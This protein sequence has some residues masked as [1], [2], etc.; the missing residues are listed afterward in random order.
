MKKLLLTIL[1]GA[2]TSWAF[3]IKPALNLN[4][5]VPQISPETSG[6]TNK[7]K[8]G[9]SGGVLFEFSI[10]PLVSLDTG[11]LLQPYVLENTSLGIVTEM[12]WKH[13]QVPVGLRIRPLPFF[14]L[15]A[16]GYYSLATGSEADVNIGGVA[17]KANLGSEQKSDYGVYGSVSLE[18]SLIP[19]L[20]LFVD[21]RYLVGLKNLSSSSGSTQKFNHLQILSGVSFGW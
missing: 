8:F 19:T 15:A 21:S 13:V 2:T 7:G 18:F 1:I 3:D 12:K 14:S 5:S 10:A 9:V 4:L 16:G 20:S 11:A 17:T 6:S